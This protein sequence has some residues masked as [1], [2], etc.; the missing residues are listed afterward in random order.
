MLGVFQINLQVMDSSV[1]ISI[2]N[3]RLFSSSIKFVQKTS[4]GIAAVPRICKLAKP[5]QF[6]TSRDLD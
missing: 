3:S 6:S 2:T 4:P 5:S 1:C